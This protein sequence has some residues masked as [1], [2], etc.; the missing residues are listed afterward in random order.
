MRHGGTEQRHD[1]VAD[2]LV[3]RATVPLHDVVGNAEIA[4]KQLCAAVRPANRA[5]GP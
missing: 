4:T 5:T 3:D 2:V 1:R